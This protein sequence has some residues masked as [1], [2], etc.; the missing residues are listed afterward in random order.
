MKKVLNQ[1]GFSAFEVL[2]VIVALAAIGAAGYFAFQA[3]QN[4][5][6][7]PAP[8]PAPVAKADPYAGWLTAKSNLDS[9]TFKY[10]SDWKIEQQSSDPD[11][12]F[13]ENIKLTSPTG[14]ILHY[15]VEPQGLG[16]GCAP[17]CKTKFGRVDKAFKVGSQQV[18]WAELTDLD[19]AQNPQVTHMGIGLIDPDV[20]DATGV[21]PTSGATV[22]YILYNF[23]KSP[24]NKTVWVRGDY[25][26]ENGNGDKQSLSESKYYSL[27]DVQKAELILKSFKY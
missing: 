11:K 23:Y 4:A 24:S 14:F 20:S 25:S 27:P 22:D 1:K 12:F 17:T 6:V 19:T 18:Y 5:A 8:A 2:L 16:G 15:T 26:D 7:K 10:P 21:V 9:L 13:D 3:R